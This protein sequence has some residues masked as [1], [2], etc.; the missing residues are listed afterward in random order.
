[1]PARWT[2]LLLTFCSACTSVPIRYYTLTPP[3]VPGANVTIS[4]ALPADA[5]GVS[6]PVQDNRVEMIVRDGTDELVPLD[7][8]HWASPLADQIRD[9]VRVELQREL[10]DSLASASGQ[11]RGAI[12]VRIDVQRMD[13]ALDRYTV[14]EATWTVDFTGSTLLDRA[15]QHMCFFRSYA[16]IS[17]GYDGV[18][19]G[20]QRQVK[21]LSDD[22]G[23]EVIALLTTGHSRCAA[24]TIAPG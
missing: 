7:N 12:R 24:N 22:I 20:Y 18:A 2:L 14:L 23:A 10:S 21:G 17:P 19:Q 1:L 5:V 6:L 11:V 15:G 8:E 16:P 13:A 9:A 4:P 3:A